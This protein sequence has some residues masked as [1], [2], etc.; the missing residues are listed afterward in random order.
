MTK[1]WVRIG[2]V[3]DANNNTM[4]AKVSYLDR[5]YAV[6]GDN[7]SSTGTPGFT[8]V[9]TDPKV[10]TPNAGD[11]MYKNVKISIG[12]EDSHSVYQLK[13]YNMH[14]GLVKSFSRSGEYKEG[15]VYWDGTDED[16]VPVRSGVYIYRIIA[17]NCVYSGTLVI[18]R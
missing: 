13:I 15:E 7:G 5:Y 9:R 10:F 4:T 14:G 1:E 2:G 3:V 18:V 16:S 17:D 6:L 11:R 12:F 8:S